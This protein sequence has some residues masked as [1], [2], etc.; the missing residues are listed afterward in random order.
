MTILSLNQV[1][2]SD[3]NNPGNFDG[4]V[5]G[6]QVDP[7]QLFIEQDVICAAPVNPLPIPQQVGN[8]SLNGPSSFFKRND[9]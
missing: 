7:S 2:S 3:I 5:E 8:R 1:E 9:G 6:Y 4:T